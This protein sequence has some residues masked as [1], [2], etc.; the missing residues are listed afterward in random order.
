MTHARRLLYPGTT[1]VAGALMLFAVYLGLVSWAESPSHAL[2]QFWQDRWLV[3]PILTGFGF[4]V[5]LYTVLKK[6]LF[7]P[8]AT[9]GPSGRLMG[10][11]GGTSTVAMVACCAHHVTDVLPVL[12]LSAAAT[13]LA[14]YRTTFMGIGLAMNLIGIMFMLGILLRE[15]RRALSRLEAATEAA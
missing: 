6:R 14:Q 7:M 1:G 5:A 11:S 4:Q 8:M 10:A 12:G 2:T 9:P 3:L 13:F 15:R